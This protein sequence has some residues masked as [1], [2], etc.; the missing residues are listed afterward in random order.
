MSQARIEQLKREI[1]SAVTELWTLVNP[2]KQEIQNVR[3]NYEQWDKDE[4]VDT[5]ASEDLDYAGDGVG[6]FQALSVVL[7]VIENREEE[8]EE[9]VVK[10]VNP[11]GPL[12]CTKPWGLA[13]ALKNHMHH[14]RKLRAGSRDRYE[15]L[16]CGKRL[17]ILSGVIIEDVE[18]YYRKKD[19]NFPAYL[20][21]LAR[22]L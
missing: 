6:W 11:S 15:C 22:G 7:D 9:Q 17:R 16:D 8:A 14:V 20:Q 1:E 18:G 21:N 19:Q 3:D 5:L 10:E 13:Q 2:T 12:S 4:L